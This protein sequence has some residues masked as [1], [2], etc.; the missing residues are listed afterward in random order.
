M[1]QHFPINY[2]QR[3]RRVELGDPSNRSSAVQPAVVII[4]LKLPTSWKLGRETENCCCCPPNSNLK[5][6]KTRIRLLARL[7]GWLVGW[8]VY[9]LLCSASLSLIYREVDLIMHNEYCQYYQTF[10]PRPHYYYFCW[11]CLDHM[12]SWPHMWS[13]VNLLLVS[14]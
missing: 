5:P 9:P 12:V 1:F 3:W 7:D 6:L 2:S 4:L 8:L 11:L 10:K 13:A 14:V